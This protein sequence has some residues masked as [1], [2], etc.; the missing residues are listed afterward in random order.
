MSRPRLRDMLWDFLLRRK[1][2]VTALEEALAAGLRGRSE[3]LTGL[4]CVETEELRRKCHRSLT[5]GLSQVV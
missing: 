3:R 5:L 4:T 1:G 2:I